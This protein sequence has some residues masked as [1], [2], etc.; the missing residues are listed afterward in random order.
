MTKKNLLFGTGGFLLALLALGAYVGLYT[1]NVRAVVDGRVYRSAQIVGPSLRATMA[2][3]LGHSLEEELVSHGV[4]T[5][6]NLRGYSPNSRWYQ[7]E[8]ALCRR[9]GVEHRDVELSDHRLPP[10][11]RLQ[12]LFEIFEKESYPIL[13][14]CQAGADRSGLI[15]ALY[16]IQYQQVPLAQAVAS[17]LS[18]RY[19]HMPFGSVQ[20]M[21]RFFHLYRETNEGLGLREWVLTRYP[22]LYQAN[23]T[24]SERG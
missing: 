8:V 3:R 17:Q 11:E 24:A 4:R 10:P 16:L 5:V 22:A 7:A 23:T 21:E 12:E 20:A 6:V 2:A 9:I 19:G 15:G 1:G 13:I 18:W 14:H